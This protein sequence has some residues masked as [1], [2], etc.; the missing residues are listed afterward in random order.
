MFIED[1]KAALIACVRKPFFTWLLLQKKKKSREI[2]HIIMYR[3]EI[4]LLPKEGMTEGKR[5]LVLQSSQGFPLRFPLC[6][7]LTML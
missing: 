3:E 2:L 4:S 1:G 6:A 5:M 7:K